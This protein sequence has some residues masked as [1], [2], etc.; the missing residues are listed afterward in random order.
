MNNNTIVTKDF[1][2]I[3]GFSN[4]PT[5]V[6]KAVIM[7]EI[8]SSKY[9]FLGLVNQYGKAKFKCRYYNVRNNLGMWT[10]KRNRK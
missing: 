2:H 1:S 9:S 7:E 8:N 10:C 6:K 4:L 3:G 5:D